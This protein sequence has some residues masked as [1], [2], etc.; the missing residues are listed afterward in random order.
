MTYVIIKR[1]FIIRALLGFAHNAFISFLGLEFP[2]LWFPLSRTSE[3]VETWRN[4]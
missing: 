3:R 1:S 4:T 2:P